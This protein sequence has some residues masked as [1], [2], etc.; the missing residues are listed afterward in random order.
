MKIL[1]HI[2]CGVCAAGVVDTLTGQGHSVTGFFYN[3]NIYPAAEYDK[4]L[5]ASREVSRRMGFELIE[6]EYDRAPWCEVSRGME[7]DPEGGARCRE[8]FR[9]RLAKTHDYFLEGQFDMFTTTLTV[10][11]KKTAGVVNKVGLEMSA[12]SF[13]QA[14]FKKKEGFKKAVELARCWDIYR[15]DYCGCEY[16]IRR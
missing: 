13:L 11:P 14:D 4:R 10:S 15:Q 12:K 5:E 3:P 6:G 8:C 16:S 7:K 9:L 1:L 2:C